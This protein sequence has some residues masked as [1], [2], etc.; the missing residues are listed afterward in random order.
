MIS[1]KPYTPPF[2]PLPAHTP[3]KSRTCFYEDL[4]FRLIRALDGRDLGRACAVLDSLKGDESFRKE[5]LNTALIFAANRGGDLENA[6]YVIEELINLGAKVTKTLLEIAIACDPPNAD[7]INYLSR[8]CDLAENFSLERTSSA[9]L[10]TNTRSFFSTQGELVLKTLKYSFSSDNL[11]PETTLPA[12][13]WKEHILPFFSSQQELA[14]LRGVSKTLKTYVDS[15]PTIPREVDYL[16]PRRNRTISYSLSA[17]VT[18]SCFVTLSGGRIATAA[19]NDLLLIDLIDYK[20]TILDTVTEPG[21]RCPEQKTLSGHT[22]PITVL[23]NFRE[24]EII[25]SGSKD[26]TLR[27][28][29]L[30]KNECIKILD[31]H[32]AAIISVIKLDDAHIASVSL[33]N[34][35][36]IWEIKSGK[37]K[38]LLDR[39]TLKDPIKTMIKLPQKDGI[40]IFSSKLVFLWGYS[41]LTE[42]TQQ[43]TEEDDIHSVHL[44]T[45]D[46]LIVNFG[47]YYSIY[48]I[49]TPFEKGLKLLR[50]IRCDN[51]TTVMHSMLPL[52]NGYVAWTVGDKIAN[53]FSPSTE[54][55]I[56]ALDYKCTIKVCHSG[57]RE[58][59]NLA[60]LADRRIA[61]L[62]ESELFIVPFAKKDPV[63]KPDTKNETENCVIS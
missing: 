7:V 60:L 37:G 32:S 19:R 55:G 13:L 62:T 18:P 1:S 46:R 23:C 34:R 54:L 31:G 39:Y 15:H 63:E 36:M 56:T 14:P 9:E 58:S 10:W 49:A 5:V 51:N 59:A 50:R 3:P 45:D 35:I 38:G 2:R 40:L 27:V 28:W 24:N 4:A 43:L 21:R 22:L 48:D 53:F 29:D 17:A 57:T 11:P 20:Y 41:T 16:K 33:D 6:C 25:I 42:W 30:K 44:L 47:S 26:T 12:E 52:S 8:Q 61:V